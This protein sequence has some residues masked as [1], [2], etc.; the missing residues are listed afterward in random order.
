MGHNFALCPFFIV[1][2]DYF[3]ANV[4]ITKVYFSKFYIEG[5]HKRGNDTKSEVNIIKLF[6]HSFYSRKIVL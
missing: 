1:S 3:I 6:S 2:T 4:S 5:L